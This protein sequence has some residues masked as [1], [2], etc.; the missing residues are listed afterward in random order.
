MDKNA[1]PPRCSGCILPS[2]IRSRLGG[3]LHFEVRVDHRVA[4]FG[5]DTSSPSEKV[6]KGVPMPR[7]T[8]PQ[9]SGSGRM[10][11]SICHGRGHTRR[12]TVNLEVEITPCYP[13]M[14][15]S[16]C[17]GRGYVETTIVVPEIDR[18]PRKAPPTSP[19]P[20]TLEGCWEAPDGSSYE[21]S[22]EGPDY[23][24][25][26]RSPAGNTSGR[27]SL[28]GRTATLVVDV[29]FLGHVKSQCEIES[30]WR[31]MTVTT[32]LMGFTVPVAFKR[33]SWPE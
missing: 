26:G 32:T 2:P 9:C 21:F 19:P 30:N 22:G 3:D 29:P 27:A 23:E 10:P 31:R 14:S 28:R 25:V 12:M 18:G 24:V 17:S 8:C 13:T 16:R 7:Q 1:A 15:C 4:V 11:C 20:S 5:P 33:V 6:A